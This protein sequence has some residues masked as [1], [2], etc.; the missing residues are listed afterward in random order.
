[1]SFAGKNEVDR[2]QEPSVAPGNQKNR[3]FQK[4][5]FFT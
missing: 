1:M 5:D 3:N 2:A 4:I